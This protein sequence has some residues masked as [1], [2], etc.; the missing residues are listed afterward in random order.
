M[1]ILFQSLKRMKYYFNK[2]Y[3]IGDDRYKVSQ[4]QNDKYDALSNL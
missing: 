1:H 4:S 2:I 3:A